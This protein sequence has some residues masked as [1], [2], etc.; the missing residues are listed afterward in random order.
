MSVVLI[1]IVHATS[2][3][4]DLEYE[5]HIYLRLKRNKAHIQTFFSQNYRIS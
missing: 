2:I 4:V 3:K 5:G 1:A